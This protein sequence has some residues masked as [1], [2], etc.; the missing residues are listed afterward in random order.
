ML[1]LI[2]GSLLSWLSL[3][4]CTARNKHNRGD[5]RAPPSFKC[6]SPSSVYRKDDRSTSLLKLFL[7]QPTL[8]EAVLEAAWQVLQVAHAA[9]A[10]CF[11]PDGLLTP[12]VCALKFSESLFGHELRS[13]AGSSYSLTARC[14]GRSGGRK[15]GELRLPDC[16]A[17]QV[18][19][20]RL[21]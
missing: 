6:K 7:G 16:I 8:S 11:P 17:D 12:V 5:Q 18:C 14:Q 10:C 3:S 4:A 20:T 15:E 2:S 19:T 9:C 13:S 1:P 21:G